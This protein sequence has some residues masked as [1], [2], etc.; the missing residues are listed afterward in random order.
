VIAGLRYIVPLKA[1]TPAS[2]YHTATLG[3]DYKDFD[4]NINRDQLGQDP[5][6]APVS[7]H[8]FSSAYNGGWRGTGRSTNYGVEMAFGFRG[9]GNGEQEFANRRFR[10][11]PNYL[12]FK[13]K[14]EHSEGLW[15]GLT[16][17]AKI[18]TQ[19]ALAPLI[20]NEQFSAGGQSSVRGYT[21]SRRL[22]DDGVTLNLE[23]RS[24]HLLPASVTQ[25]PK[26]NA[27][28]FTDAAYLRVQDALPGEPET[29]DL[30]SAGLGLSGSLF[31][32]VDF[33][34]EWAHAFATA[35][36]VIADNDNDPTTAPPTSNGTVLSG[37]DRLHFSVGYD[38]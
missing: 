6:L 15:K 28:L 1:T 14:L 3:L 11:E 35:T 30:S 24:P 19:A 23:L 17:V 25:I 13:G 7:Y 33:T 16:A 31:G 5:I 38:F 36:D 37:D 18:N 26:L 9:L 34:L 20:S 4:E 22:G 27:Y 2:F 21:E 32:E 29:F 10:G 8:R 12:F